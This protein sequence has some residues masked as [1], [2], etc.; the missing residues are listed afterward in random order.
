MMSIPDAEPEERPGEP[1]TR[2]QQDKVR[3]RQEL[4][5]AA[6]RLFGTR[7]FSAVTLRDVGAEAG[8]TAQAIYRH[9][10]SKEELLAQLL[11][12][13]SEGLLAGGARIM[14]G[15][16]D[17][18]ERVD[19][20]IDFHVEF[21]L[22]SPGV[23]RIQEQELPRMGEEPRHL[24]R[25]RQREYLDLWVAAMADLHGEES[26]SALRHRAHAVFGLMNST[27]HFGGEQAVRRD[28]GAV[29]HLT[30]LARAVV[31]AR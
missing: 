15:A 14:E 22:R 27:A 9:F 8:V 16:G 23:I 11:L 31:R 10:A 28:S 29:E 19:R 12:E 13:V 21:S 20:L 18:G 25:R 26:S 6:G 24:I 30:M 5:A 2:R 17:P 7:G 1:R 4:L 3:R